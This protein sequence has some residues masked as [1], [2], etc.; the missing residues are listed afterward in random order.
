MESLDVYLRLLNI[1]ESHIQPPM[2]DYFTA[3]SQSVL[4]LFRFV[5]GVSDHNAISSKLFWLLRKV[6]KDFTFVNSG[7]KLADYDRPK[8]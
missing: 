5:L 3:G 1:L 2:P 8:L 6:A 7:A 4:L